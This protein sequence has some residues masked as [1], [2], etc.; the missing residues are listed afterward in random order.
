[1][2]MTPLI[3][4][5]ANSEI[6]WDVLTCIWTPCDIVWI[7]C[8]ILIIDKVMIHTRSTSSTPTI[9][10]AIFD[11]YFNSFKIMRS[12]TPF[13]TFWE[14]RCLWFKCFSFSFFSCHLCGWAM[15]LIANNCKYFLDLVFNVFYQIL[16][17]ILLL[18]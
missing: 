8:H 4:P 17:I 7:I 14:S 10:K 15:S 16:M 9:I 11:N 12:L 1:M 6:L 3:R 2:D 5:W 18:R 13:H